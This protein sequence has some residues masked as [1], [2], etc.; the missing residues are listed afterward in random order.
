MKNEFNEMQKK[1]IFHKDGPLIIVAGP[2]SGKTTVIVNRAKEM[3]DTYHIKPQE[4]LI[5]TFTKNAALEMAARYNEICSINGRGV[6]FGTIHAICL[7]F[8]RNYFGY[9]YD[10]LCAENEKYGKLYTIYKKYHFQ[11]GDERKFIKAAASGISNIKNMRKDVQDPSTFAGFQGISDYQMEK[12]Y[13]SYM[14]E[15]EKE[16]KYDFDDILLLCHKHLLEEPKVLSVIQDTYRYIM[17]DEF[18]DTNRIQADIFYLIAEKY[19]NIVI[20]GDDDQS[21]YRFRAADPSIMLSFRKSFP[22]AEKVILGINYRSDGNIVRA[23]RKFIEKNAERYPKDLQANRQSQEG[24]HFV[25]TEDEKEE[26]NFIIDKVKREHDKGIPYGE[27]AVIYRTNKESQPI[28]GKFMEKDIPFYAKKDD[29]IDIYSHFIY[30]DILNF[31]ELANGSHDYRK[32]QRA[33]KRPT[34]YITG[35]C[36]KECKN[37]DEIIEWYLERGNRKKVKDII[38]F[39]EKIQILNNFPHPKDLIT[40]IRD[41]MGY[42]KGLE[43]YAK[44][45]HESIDLLNMILD[46]LEKDASQFFT[47][48]D[49]IQYGQAYHERI[50]EQTK[51]E[52]GADAVSLTTMHG[53][54]G[55]EYKVVFLINAVNGV[56]PNKNAETALELQ[57]ERRMFYVAMTR[58]KDQL[59]IIKPET[60]YEDKAE[61]S[62]YYKQMLKICK[63]EQIPYE[64]LDGKIEKTKLDVKNGDTLFHEKY[65]EGKVLDIN[66][67]KIYMAFGNEFKIFP[68]P[69]A[70]EE[71]KLTQNKKAKENVIRPD[72]YQILLSPTLSSPGNSRYVIVDPETGE[73]IRDCSGYGYKT[74]ESAMNV[75]IRKNN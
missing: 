34:L 60:Y 24:I 58:A 18:Q 7:N 36:F 48:K 55:L 5:S 4:I 50:L 75:R 19:R 35:Q 71:K 6:N 52:K 12:M 30:K 11:T 62:P 33:M 1:A 54:K 10:K 51:W 9:S 65:G 23:T 56:T 63:T 70:I 31:W 21:L 15:M 39:K 13:F 2:G 66:G 26:T 22:E 40:F 38:Q 45:M 28:N 16:E 72:G 47:M 73:V 37:V 32:W 57:E 67:N 29:I 43:N 46:D 61:P 68:Y 49:W 44:Y 53:S 17:I 25:Q 59:Y 64:V 20:V 69:Q 42:E 41:R 74:V 27:M 3:I 8:L 14:E